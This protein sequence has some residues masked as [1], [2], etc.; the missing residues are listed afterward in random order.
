MA[1]WRGPPAG[2]ARGLVFQCLSPDVSG[3]A[4][5]DKA[6]GPD[7]SG[8]DG[9]GI[10]PDNITRRAILSGCRKRHPW[11]SYAAFLAYSLAVCMMAARAATSSADIMP[12]MPARASIKAH[13]V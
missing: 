13:G 2:T 5:P 12:T 11:R 6:T 7:V 8:T 10:N 4:N 9:E 1:T 3:E